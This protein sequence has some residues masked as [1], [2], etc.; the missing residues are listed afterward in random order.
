MW[1]TDNCRLPQ[2]L[3]RWTWQR[4]PSWGIPPL[5]LPQSLPY[6]VMRARSA[7]QEMGYLEDAQHTQE[8]ILFSVLQSW[9]GRASW[10]HQRLLCKVHRCVADLVIVSSAALAEAGTSQPSKA[11][12]Q[13]VARVIYPMLLRKSH[14]HSLHVCCFVARITKTCA[15]RTAQ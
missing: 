12:M 9:Q 13:Q 11:E 10:K 2:M 8:N 7:L 3:F 1:G 4:R 15:G 6:V 14:S 5:Q